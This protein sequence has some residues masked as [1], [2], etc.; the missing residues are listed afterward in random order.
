MKKWTV[1]LLSSL[2]AVAF[3][4]VPAAAATI[5]TDFSGG[6]TCGQVMEARE[7]ISDDG[8]LHARDGLITCTTVVDDDRYSGEEEVTINYNFQFAPSPVF[9]YGPMWGKI[10]VSNEGG[11]WEGSWVGQRTELQGFSYIQAVLRGF[12][13]YEGLQARVDYIRL[14]PAPTAPY[15]VHGVIMDPGGK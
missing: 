1:I 5:R 14:S 15:Q 3:V 2:I 11:F 6:S 9:V 4:I 12:G 13:D 7:W 8:V 10:R